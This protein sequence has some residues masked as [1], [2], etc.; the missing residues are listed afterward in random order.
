MNRYIP[1]LLASVIFSLA[2]VTATGM[3]VDIKVMAQCPQLTSGL[4]VPLG[5][6]QSD[7]SNLF[8]SESGTP[9]PNTGRISI[10]DVGGNRRTLLDGLPSGINDVNEISGP[11]GLFLHEKTL[12]VAIGIGD[13]IKPGP[14][15]GTAVPNPNPPASPIFSS[16]LAIHFSNYVERNTTGFTLTSAD[17]Q[18]LANG[19]RVTKSNGGFD[20]I[21]VELIANFPDFFAEPLVAVPSLIAVPNNVRGSNP[22]DLVLVEGRRRHDGDTRDHDDEGDDSEPGLLYVTDGGRNLVWRVDINSGA[23][24]ILA[25]FPQVANPMFPSLG[26]PFMD[27]VPTG[28]AES[29]GHLLVTLF[30]GVPFPPGTSVVAQVNQLTGNPTPFITGRKTAIDV[31]PITRRGDTDY[32]VL[33]HASAGPFFGSPGLLLRFETPTDPPDIIA[34]CLTRPTSMALDKKTGTLYVTELVPVPPGQPV[35]LGRIVAIN[36]AP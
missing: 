14:A 16:V 4:Q 15:P 21:T 12:Y 26:P 13:T 29:Q 9:L 6:A 7:K 5:I 34:S 20:R 36:V 23:F 28:I 8:V 11:A 18:S 31:L 3:L 30:R 33:Q 35:L 32:L 22:F 10:V 1:R 24:S 2:L 17:H 25:V 19:E 27:A